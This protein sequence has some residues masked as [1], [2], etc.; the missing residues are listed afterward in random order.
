MEKTKNTISEASI[1]TLVRSKLQKVM[2]ELSKDKEKNPKDVADYQPPQPIAGAGAADAKKATD[3]I[4]QPQIKEKPKAIATDIN[5][6]TASPVDLNQLKNERIAR[7][8][9]AVSNTSK[10]DLQF[11][12]NDTSPDTKAKVIK[13]FL[14]LIGVPAEDVSAILTTA[15]QTSGAAKP[16][17][18][19]DQAKAN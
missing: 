8:I 3:V 14:K 12:I 18:A 7:F 16:V 13:L 15:S 2:Q 1:R 10:G 4:P 6:P 17:S 11:I 9:Q 5:D 19:I